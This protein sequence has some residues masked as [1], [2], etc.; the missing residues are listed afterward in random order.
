MWGFG[1]LW[2]CCRVTGPGVSLPGSTEDK[3]CLTSEEGRCL[4]GE[5]FMACV[6]RTYPS[7]LSLSKDQNAFCRPW[8]V[9]LKLKRGSPGFQGCEIA[10]AFCRRG[11]IL[12]ATMAAIDPPLPPPNAFLPGMTDLIFQILPHFTWLIASLGRQLCLWP[13]P[14]VPQPVFIAFPLLSCG[15][16]PR[17]AS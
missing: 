11:R 15:V 4:P 8:E 14:Q 6:F 13:P 10:L 7:E 5:L 2:G 17:L 3:V 9:S 1:H 16:N 12:K